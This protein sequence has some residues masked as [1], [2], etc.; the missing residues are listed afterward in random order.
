MNA[1]L[2]YGG[3]PLGVEA[4]LPVARPVLRRTRRLLI[5]LMAVVRRWA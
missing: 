2:R 4:A 3:V 1:D 5:W